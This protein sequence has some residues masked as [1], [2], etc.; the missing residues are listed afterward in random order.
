MTEKSFKKRVE[1]ITDGAC[2]GNPGPGGWAALLRFGQVEKL[3]TGNASDTT[4]NRMELKAVIEGLRALKEPCSVNILTDSQ[5]V[6]NAF[7][8]GWIVNWQRNGWRTADKKPVKNQD[9]WEKL[10][11]LLQVHQVGWTWVKG[12]NGHVDNELVDAAAR[13]AAAMASKLP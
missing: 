5:Y 3:L 8:K 13:D 11:A 1:L 2:L 12:H 4:N 6:M 9:L 10:D 7:E